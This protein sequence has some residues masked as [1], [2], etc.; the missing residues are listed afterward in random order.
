VWERRSIKLVAGHAAKA[1]DFE[2][3]VVAPRCSAAFLPANTLLSGAELPLLHLLRKLDWHGPWP[4]QRGWDAARCPSV[5]SSVHMRREREFTTSHDEGGEGERE[6]ELTA[7]PL[8]VS[9]RSCASSS[10]RTIHLSEKENSLPL[11]VNP[12]DLA[13]A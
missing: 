13:G 1:N 7:L 5:T 10:F 3:C 6:R 4:R 11:H 12:F 9:H 2:H 8:A